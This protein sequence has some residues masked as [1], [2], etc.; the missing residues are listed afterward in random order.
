MQVQD[1]N[2]TKHLKQQDTHACISCTHTHT[3]ICIHTHASHTSDKRKKTPTKPQ[4]SNQLPSQQTTRSC[5]S[6]IVLWIDVWY[7]WATVDLQQ[8]GYSPCSWIITFFSKD[9]CTTTSVCSLCC[10]TY[11]QTHQAGKWNPPISAPTLFCYQCQFYRPVL[12]LGL[13][14]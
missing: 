10:F 9:P 5:V 3:H 14:L 1:Q 2:K 13:S 11:T 12:Q 7:L 4:A 6:S 8:Y